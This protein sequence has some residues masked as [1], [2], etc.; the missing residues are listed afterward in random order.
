MRYPAMP[1]EEPRPEHLTHD[2]IDR[3]RN[4]RTCEYIQTNASTL[5]KYRGLPQM[6]ALPSRA[7]LGNPRD[8][9]SQAPAR[10]ISGHLH[11]V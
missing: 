7:L 1:A 4:H 3:R 10:M 11:T 6:Q 8:C 9:A 5:G 2:A